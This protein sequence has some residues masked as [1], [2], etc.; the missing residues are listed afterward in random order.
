MD[1]YLRDIFRNTGIIAK[2]KD[3]FPNLFQMSE[4]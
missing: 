4:L 2:I 1:Y 3:I